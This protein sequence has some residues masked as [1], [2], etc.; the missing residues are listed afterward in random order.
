MNAFPWGPAT[1]V[2]SM[3]GGDAREAAKT[4]AG[5]VEDFP[6]CPSSLPVGPAPT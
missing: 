4:V 2:G 3:P 5:S 1:G 6:T